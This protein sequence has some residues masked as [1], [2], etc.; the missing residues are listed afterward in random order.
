[1][2]V[3]F[4]STGRVSGWE[5]EIDVAIMTVPLPPRFS[6]PFWHPQMPFSGE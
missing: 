3:L 1:M 5:A 4:Y 2:H 6:L